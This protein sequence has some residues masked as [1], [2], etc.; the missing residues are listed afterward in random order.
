MLRVGGRRG[1]GPENESVEPIYTWPWTHLYFLGP[2][3]LLDFP[4]AAGGDSFV[5]YVEILLK[6]LEAGASPVNTAQPATEVG[7]LVLAIASPSISAATAIPAAVSS[8]AVAA[9]SIS[10]AVTV[11][12][13]CVM[14]V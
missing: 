6:V 11:A 13:C 12:H 2:S 5:L 4:L 10:S 7:H 3:E 1:L 9:S 14:M 8:S